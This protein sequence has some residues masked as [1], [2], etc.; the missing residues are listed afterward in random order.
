M[1]DDLRKLPDGKYLAKPTRAGVL[2]LVKALTGREPTPEELARGEAILAQREGVVVPFRQREDDDQLTRGRR[3]LAARHATAM[4][5]N[6]PQQAKLAGNERETESAE[7]TDRT[8][9]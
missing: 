4:Q 3:D 7:V 8:D 5:R 9:G 2:A 6:Q 1:T